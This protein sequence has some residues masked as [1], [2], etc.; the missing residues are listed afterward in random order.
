VRQI[1]TLWASSPVGELELEPAL[2]WKCATC[3]WQRYRIKQP[4]SLSDL[5][6]SFL[7]ALIKNRVGVGILRGN[8]DC[9]AAT[10]HED[11]NILI[12]SNILPRERSQ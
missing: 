8:E 2:A 6:Q 11:R 1:L 3:F 4:F 5:A 9:I 7:Q 12:T 10:P